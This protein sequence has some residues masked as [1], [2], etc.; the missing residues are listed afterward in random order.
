MLNKWLVAVCVSIGYVLGKSHFEDVTSTGAGSLRGVASRTHTAD[1]LDRG[2]MAD[3]L[4]VHPCKELLNTELL[5]GNV[6]YP[7]PIFRIW[8]SFDRL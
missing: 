8:F 1:Q 5:Q 7:C 2:K 6:A 4:N 3:A